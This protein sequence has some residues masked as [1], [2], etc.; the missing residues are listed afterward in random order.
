MSFLKNVIV[1]NYNTF[2][3][4]ITISNSQIND[5][6]YVGNNTAINNSTIGKFCSIGPEVKIGLGKHP[7]H[8]ISSF[9]AFFSTHKQ[10]QITF[11]D[12]NYFKETGKIVIG[13]DVWIGSNATIM[14]DITIGDGAIIAAGSI[15]TK[16]IEPYSI[17]GGVPA[18]QIKKRFSPDEII[19]LE[20]FKWWD[21][22]IN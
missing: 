17:V 4:D 15:V 11:A 7:S 2:Y 18:H 21:K 6:V 14:Y 8:Y 1:G 16:D 19:L 9:P 12:K 20:E 22:D 10:C 13:N 5:F 3:N